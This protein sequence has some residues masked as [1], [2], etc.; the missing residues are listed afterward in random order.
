MMLISTPATPVEVRPKP[1][2]LPAALPRWRA[3]GAGLVVLGAALLIVG[4]TLSIN[5]MLT[6]LLAINLPHIGGVALAAGVVILLFARRDL[7]RLVRQGRTDPADPP[8]SF[9]GDFARA[10]AAILGTFM[11]VYLGWELAVF[12]RVPSLFMGAAWLLIGAA[13]ASGLAHVFATMIR[14]KGPAR[15][16]CGCGYRFG[17]ASEDQAPPCC[18]ECGRP[19]RGLLWHERGPI[20]LPGV[21]VS[22]ALALL[23]LSLLGWHEP[24]VRAA[25]APAHRLLLAVEPPTSPFWLRAHEVPPS[26]ALAERT[27]R[28]LIERWRATGRWGDAAVWLDESSRRG[29]LSREL[30]IDLAEVQVRSLRRRVPDGPPIAAPSQIIGLSMP[31]ESLLVPGQPVPV[32]T[33][34]AAAEG[35]FVPLE[36]ARALD[37]SFAATLMGLSGPLSL[38]LPSSPPIGEGTL[39]VR[40]ELRDAW[41]SR[42]VR[43]IDLTLPPP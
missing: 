16:C 43:T 15:F 9:G 22:V 12:V 30:L 8:R 24:L 3:I 23:S 13:L 33:A 39:R 7:L 19:W 25:L 31:G 21:L 20:R 42:S 11:L 2:L 6:T 14:Q 35:P 27:A 17:Y 40:I 28:R 37:Q 10:M 41:D 36:R 4:H 32:L 29:L 5:S 38:V 18:T 1:H 26:P 34:F